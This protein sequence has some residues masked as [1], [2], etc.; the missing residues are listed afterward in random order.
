M[1]TIN[2]IIILFILLLL[3]NNL[4]EGKLVEKIKS[5]FTKCKSKVEKFIG[6]TY[7]NSK[8]VYFGNAEFP[9]NEQ[10]DFTYLSNNSPDEVSYNLYRFLNSLVIPNVNNYAM[11]AANSE[12]L[13]DDDMNNNV[14][15]SIMKIFNTSGYNFSNIQIID[16]IYYYENT[17]GKDIEPFSFTADVSYRNNEIGQIKVYMEAFFKRETNMFVILNIRL[18]DIQYANGAE[19]KENIW[20]P[21][22]MYK[23]QPHEIEAME[24]TKK[25]AE[26]MDDSFNNYFVKRDDNEL[27]I[28]PDYETENSLIPSYVNLDD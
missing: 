13:Q 11:F 24:D 7:T 20:Y 17:R 1:N 4:V 26:K 18:Q 6:L 28:K 9:Y 8:G 25:L 15:N 22:Q 21:M 2:Q 19:S 5:L 27:F 14:I 10:K 3:I 16:D 23:I 12:R